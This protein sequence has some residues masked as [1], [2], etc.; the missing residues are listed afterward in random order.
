MRP[1]S[2]LCRAPRAL[3]LH[4]SGILLT[5]LLVD[6]GALAGVVAM[7]LGR[8]GGVLLVLD[9]LNVLRCRLVLALLLAGELVGDAALILWWCLR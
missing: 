5:Q 8:Q 1:K 2:L 3:T 4:G 9:T 7:R 6:L